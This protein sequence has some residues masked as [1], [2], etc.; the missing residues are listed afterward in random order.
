[1]YLFW[2]VITYSKSPR[3][4]STTT[5]HLIQTHQEFERGRIAQGHIDEPVMSKR[6]HRGKGGALLASTLG[7]GGD[8]DAD[9]FTPVAARLPLLAGRVPEGL[10]L[11]G[12][13]AVTGGDAEE[14]GV[15]F[16]ELVWGDEGDG[17]GLA[18]GVHFAEDFLGQGFLD[19]VGCQW[20]G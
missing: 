18:G 9:V 17:V 6:T 1:M 4:P 7:S 20:L 12:E 3:A 16:F 14:E 10:P 11:G 19:P 13:V 2:G 15:V 5:P 8:E